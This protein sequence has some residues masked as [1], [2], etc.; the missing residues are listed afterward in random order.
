M[1][2]ASTWCWTPAP[3]AARARSP[4]PSSDAQPPHDPLPPGRER[5]GEGGAARAPSRPLTPPSPQRGEGFWISL[6][7]QGGR[8]QGE[9]GASPAELPPHPTLSPEGRGILDLPLPPR[10]ERAG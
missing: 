9:G 3:I 5:A 8:G 2:P 6:S 1:S 7:L 4:W 10:R